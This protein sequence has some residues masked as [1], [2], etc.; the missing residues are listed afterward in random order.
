MIELID[1]GKDYGE[2]TAVERLNLKIDAGE[3][4][5]FIGPNGAGKSTSI[6]FLATL[7][8]ATRG[9][10]IVNGHSVTGDPMAVRHSVG[11]MPDNFGVYD[12]MRVWE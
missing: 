8:K 2:F 3:M 9:E 10:G 12:G 6:R 5:G 1:F 7:L 4:F 11:Y